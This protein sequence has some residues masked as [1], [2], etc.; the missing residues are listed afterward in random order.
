MSILIKNCRIISSDVDI[1]HASLEI[2]EDIISKIY[3]EETPLPKNVKVY[4]AEN[5]IAVPGFIDVHTHGAMGFDVMD[6]TDEAIETVAAAKLKEGV[7][8]FCATTVTASEACLEKACA[9]V[10]RYQVDVKR[11][12]AKIPGVHLEGPFI[13][14]EFIGAQNPNF[15]RKPDIDEVLRLNS[16]SRIM[17]DSYA[18]EM[19]EKRDFAVELIANGILPSCAHSAATYKQFKQAKTAGVKHLTHF[20]NQMLPLHHREIGLVGA[21]L[22]D[23]DVMVEAIC[24]KVH[25]GEDMIRLLFK[26]KPIEKISMI[27]D[28]VPASG[29]PDGEFTIGGLVV[30][31]KDNIARLKS[32]G[33]LAGGTT[34]YWQALKN[35]YKLTGLPLKKLIKTTGYNQAQELGLEKTGKIEPGFYADIAVL[36]A[37]FKPMMVFVNGKQ[38]L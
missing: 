31:V 21:G 11:Q 12:T 2:S 25:L 14:P 26:I 3:S 20:C 6:G 5:C 24:D 27:T 9:A 37:N 7:T 10:S 28:S 16:I 4:N 34:P 13:N 22:M 19:D 23:N 8:S 32:N 38:K 1:E 18:I 33:A 17:L 15:I 30:V 36:D 35:I 29:L